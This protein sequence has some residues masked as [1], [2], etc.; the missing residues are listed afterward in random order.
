MNTYALVDKYQMKWVQCVLQIIKIVSI[1][2]L[3]VLLLGFWLS[4]P[5]ETVKE[6]EAQNASKQ[7]K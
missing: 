7:S 2:I 5:E 4:A 3:T 1:I 6:I